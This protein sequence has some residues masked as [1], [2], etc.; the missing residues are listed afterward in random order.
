MLSMIGEQGAGPRLHVADAR[1]AGCRSPDV[2]RRRPAGRVSV[3]EC[4]SPMPGGAALLGCGPPS[5]STFRSWGPPRPRLCAPAGAGAAGSSLLRRQDVDPAAADRGVE[6]GGRLPRELQSKHG[7][8]GKPVVDRGP[9]VAAVTGLEDAFPTSGGDM[10]RIEGVDRGG[11]QRT[12][13]ADDR[14]LPMAAAVGAEKEAA[15]E[16]HTA[17]LAVGDD[18]FLRVPRIDHDGGRLPGDF[19]H[20][21][22]RVGRLDAHDRLE[23]AV[24]VYVVVEPDGRRTAVQHGGEGLCE[25]E[26]REYLPVVRRG[27]PVEH[28]GPFVHQEGPTY[29]RELEA[30]VLA[31][32]IPVPA[33]VHGAVHQSRG[34]V[35]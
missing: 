30:P 34:G 31:E 20:G 21:G 35:Q 25:V 32:R 3:L 29:D 33:G 12:A 19:Q 28:L 14:V 1:R 7:P 5:A 26:P 10:E 23:Y 18:D 17:V 4:M 27:V 13:G 6:R 9:G 11:E 15:R 22:K 16:R 2:Y 8:A 24:D